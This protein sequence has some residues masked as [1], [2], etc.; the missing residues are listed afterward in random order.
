MLP[1]ALSSA[2]I[3]MNDHTSFWFLRNVLPAAPRFITCNLK[4]LL[5]KRTL[6]IAFRM[7]FF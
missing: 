5:D 4:S 3:E 2:S 6:I 1:R 7:F